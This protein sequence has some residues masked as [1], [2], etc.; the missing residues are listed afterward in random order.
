MGFD[1]KWSCS[2]YH[3]ERGITKQ[4]KINPLLYESKQKSLVQQKK[5]SCWVEEWV[6]FTN[7][8]KVTSD[9]NLFTWIWI[10]IKQGSEKSLFDT[11]WLGKRSCPVEKWVGGF[12]QATRHWSS[13]TGGDI[14]TTGISQR[15]VFCSAVCAKQIEIA[16]LQENFWNP[17][18]FVCL[19][20]KVCLCRCAVQ[21]LTLTGTAAGATAWQ[22]WLTTSEY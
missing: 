12:Y 19:K 22:M 16:P 10:A 7:Q 21:F 13:D 5:W 17:L 4:A 18:L 2:F 20:P 14:W 15:P 11:F 8:R 3:P 9:S 6:G 1:K